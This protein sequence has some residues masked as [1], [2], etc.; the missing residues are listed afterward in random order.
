MQPFYFGSSK[1]QLFGIYHAP[2]VEPAKSTGVVLC[3]PLGHEYLRAH[4][5]FRN[6][7]VS[8]AGLGFHVLRFD[9]YGA[10][11]SSGEAEDVTIGQCLTDL[12]TAIDELKDTAGVSSVSLIGV[13]FG[14]TLAAL[15]AAR[16][17]DVDRL[18][19]WDPEQDGR[20][21]IEQLATLQRNWLVDRLGGVP[22]SLGAGELIGFALTDTV[23]A[24][25]EAITLVPFPRVQAK[26]VFV[27]TSEARPSYDALLKEIES[28]HRSVTRI[29][30]DEPCDWD[31]GDMVHQIL[32]PHAMVRS[33]TGVMSA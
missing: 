20:G 19:L 7:A 27:M 16:R 17:R 11:D 29:G 32:L 14:A 13:R 33:I 18:V 2:D 9:Y 22:P 30:V 10:G 3:H 21:Y 25:L 4:R 24:E 23:R 28:A 31:R 5:A 12:G 8:L 15:A 26:A 6:L 1:K